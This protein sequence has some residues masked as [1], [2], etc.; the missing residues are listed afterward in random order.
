M[1]YYIN[2]SLKVKFY[3]FLSYEL[4][5]LKDQ[6]LVNFMSLFINSREIMFYYCVEIGTW[7]VAKLTFACDASTKIIFFAAD[8]FIYS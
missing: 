1:N 5:I 8:I 6:N 2:I 7:T 4:E 3:A